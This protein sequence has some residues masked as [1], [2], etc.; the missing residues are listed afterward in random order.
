M[1]EQYKAFFSSVSHTPHSMRLNLESQTIESLFFVLLQ[2][3][4]NA[5]RYMFPDKSLTQLNQN[6]FQRINEKFNSLG[7][8][9][10]LCYEKPNPKGDLSKFIIHIH[11]LQVYLYFDY[12]KP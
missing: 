4:Q 7:I 9:V 8:D 10:K 3:L 1:D 12:L 11:E 6:D 5:P 2:I